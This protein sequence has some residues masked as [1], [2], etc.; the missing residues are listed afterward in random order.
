MRKE[1]T[2]FENGI[3]YERTRRQR[4]FHYIVGVGLGVYGLGTFPF[5]PS[6]GFSFLVFC[7]G[8]VG[9]YLGNQDSKELKK[10]A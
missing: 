1:R 3:G 7:I 9:V 8:V 10:Y 6:R 2:M 4:L 5:S